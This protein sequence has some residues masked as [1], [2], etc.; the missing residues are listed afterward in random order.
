MPRMRVTTPPPPCMPLGLIMPTSGA[1]A[2]AHG[3]NDPSAIR[4]PPRVVVMAQAR[5]GCASARAAPAAGRG[6]LPCR[7][8]ARAAA[9]MGRLVGSGSR[10][11]PFDE[12]FEP[13]EGSLE[14][15]TVTA[16]RKC[17]WQ[18]VNVAGAGNGHC[19]A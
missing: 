17:R 12:T 16:V 4:R 9:R 8:D 7:T 14:A 10:P 11:G 5:P 18:A 13:F 6:L 15:A 2:V 1:V 19:S 3:K